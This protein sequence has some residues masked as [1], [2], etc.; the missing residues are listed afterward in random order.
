MRKSY[1]YII[2]VM[3]VLPWGASAQVQPNDTTLTRTVVVENEYTPNI[4]DAQKINV[5]PKVEPLQSSQKQVEYATALSAYN[6]L[7][8]SIMPVLAG[9]DKPNVAL[10]GYVRF[11]LGLPGNI[12]FLGNYHYTIS[13]QDEVNLSAL[14]NGTK[15]DR[16]NEDGYIWEGA[17]YY[18][19]RAGVDYTHTFDR[20]KLDLGAHLGVS[21]FNLV[22]NYWGGNQN[23]TSGDLH[24]GYRSSDDNQSLIYNVESNLTMY[25]RGHDINIEILSETGLMTRGNF[26]APLENQQSVGIGF[27]LDNFFYGGTYNNGEKFKGNHFLDLNPY[28]VYDNNGWKFHLGAHVG[29]NFGVQKKFRVAPDL[30]AE[31]HIDD[32][33]LF[34]AHATGGH[35]ASDLRRLEQLNPYGQ[36]SSYTQP[37]NTYEQ[38]NIHLGVKGTP[39]IGLGINVFAGFQTLKDDAGFAA[40]FLD[41][42]ELDANDRTPSSS[43][44][45][46]NNYGIR[47][48]QANTH[49]LYGGAAVDYDYQGIVALHLNAVLRSWGYDKENWRAENLV[50]FKPVLEG[51][52]YVTARPMVGLPVTIGYQFITR[53]GT[54]N[55]KPKAVGNLYL[56]A[57]YQ[58]YKELSVYARINNIFNQ[59]YQYFSGIPAQ[60]INFV[61][62]ISY[63]F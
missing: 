63:C 2:G 25:K 22:Q 55:Y 6:N 43:G 49:N 3:L 18:Q 21:N 53:K 26:L 14:F 9:V 57:S 16:T 28:Y 62:G 50:S 51:D 17:R 45:Y 5:L 7:P 11:G 29:Y 41:S 30:L 46:W 19:T 52:A 34:Y 38:A 61:G 40:E 23:L 59:K 44:W 27:L 39:N 60:G 33:Y 47:L 37:L 54:D 4:L 10:P 20:S 31:Y 32:H 15:G 8:S 13:E 42:E 1:I 35:L 12:D 36:L 24:F 56:N 48:Y 58:V